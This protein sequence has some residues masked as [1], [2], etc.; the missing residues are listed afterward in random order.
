M[1]KKKTNNPRITP[2]EIEVI[3]A[4]QAG[5]KSAFNTL[6]NKYKGFVDSVVYQYLKDM[7]E[8]K[9]V[10]NI[11]FLKVYEKLSTFRAY[12]SFGGWLRVIANRTAI[13]YLRET[14]HD[15]LA[16]DNFDARLALNDSISSDEN[17]LVNRMTFEQVT[18]VFDQFPEQVKKVCE[19]FY[20]EN[21]TVEQIGKALR[22]P[23][24]TVKSHLSRTR[25]KLKK[26]I[27]N[28]Y[29]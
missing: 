4:A 22:I 12:D 20:V 25:S 8:S 28:N 24:G 13:D 9:D 1:K 5:S 17:D 18:K 27:K 11:V 3:K 26:Q 6:Y 21:L 16:I 2:E 7:D 23:T 19:L 15:P 29:Q 14:K 10:A